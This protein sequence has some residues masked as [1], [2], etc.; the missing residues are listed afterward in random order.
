MAGKF[1]HKFTKS[2]YEVILK[3]LIS[4]IQLIYLTIK[5]LKFFS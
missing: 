3:A 2:Q 1:E 5:F 4:S